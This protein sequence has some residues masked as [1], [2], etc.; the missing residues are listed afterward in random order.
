LSFE[1]EEQR[2]VFFSRGGGAQHSTETNSKEE[3]K[4]EEMDTSKLV[5]PLATG[6]IGLGSYYLVRPLAN[7]WLR[8]VLASGSCAGALLSLRT[9]LEEGMTAP[10]LTYQVV[11]EPVGG[12]QL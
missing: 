3:E 1:Q 11:V 2:A 7:P 10:T 5:V 8:G 12:E 6:A 9:V 4:A